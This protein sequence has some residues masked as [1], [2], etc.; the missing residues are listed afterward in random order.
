MAIALIGLLA[1]SLLFILIFNLKSDNKLIKFGLLLAGNGCLIM[2][3]FFA[4]QDQPLNSLLMNGVILFISNILAIRHIYK[5][6]SL[7]QNL[8][9]KWHADPNNWK[10]GILYYNTDDKRLFPPKRVKGLGWTIN[11]A[12]PNSI[13]AF[14]GVLLII[15]TFVKL[16]SYTS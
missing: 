3:M 8:F 2:A 9:D 12:N 13:L 11:F 15:I 14:L 10:A 5:P 4:M 7:N 16:L 1:G 6:V